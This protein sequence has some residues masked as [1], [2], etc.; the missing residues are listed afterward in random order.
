VREL[1]RFN[2]RPRRRAGRGRRRVVES[3]QQ[4]AILR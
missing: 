3:R 2:H 1:A 4:C